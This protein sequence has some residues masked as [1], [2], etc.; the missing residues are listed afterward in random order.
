MIFLCKTSPHNGNRLNF[1]ST[2][3]LERLKQRARKIKRER[4]IQ[5]SVALELVA[6]SAHFDNWHQVV[7]AHRAMHATELAVREGVVIAM[8]SK[9][10]AENCGAEIPL[11]GESG[12]L[13]SDEKLAF[14][15]KEFFYRT[16]LEGVDEED[17]RPNREKWSDEEL[18]EFAEERIQDLVF[19][20]FVGDTPP[21]DVLTVVNLVS[22]ACFWGPEIVWIKGKPHDTYSLPGDDD[23]GYVRF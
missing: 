21:T 11:P 5:H 9:E 4:G 22:E 12:R 8:D 18:H 7:T 17:G 1:I 2:D 23:R 16:E 13:V 10:V 19:Y 3:D 15:F 14:F 6:Q 20:R